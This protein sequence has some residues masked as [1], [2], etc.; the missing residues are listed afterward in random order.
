[1]IL[2]DEIFSNDD[3]DLSVDE[4]RLL[5]HFVRRKLLP[6][7]EDSTGAGLVLRTKQEVL[8]FITRENMEKYKGE[9]ERDQSAFS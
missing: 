8:S 5:C 6:M 7:F 1:M 9:L 3:S 2:L 4:L